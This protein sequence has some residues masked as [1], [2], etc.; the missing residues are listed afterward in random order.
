MTWFGW[1]S[2]RDNQLDGKPR[3]F[4]LEAEEFHQSSIEN[5]QIQSR[6]NQ[7]LNNPSPTTH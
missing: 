6:L 1:K 3:D 4:S 2:E 5:S 7:L